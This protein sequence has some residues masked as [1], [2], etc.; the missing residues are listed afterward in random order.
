MWYDQ[1][2][3]TYILYVYVWICMYGYVWVN[4]YIYMYWCKCTNMYVLHV[5]ACKYVLNV[6]QVYAC[7]VCISMYACI[8]CIACICM[9][10]W[11]TLLEIHANTYIYMQYT[12]ILKYM[13][14]MHNVSMHVLSSIYVQIWSLFFR[15]MKTLTSCFTHAPPSPH[16]AILIRIT[17]CELTMSC[18]VFPGSVS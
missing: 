9:Y 7:L 13:Q 16:L 4:A 18:A 8:V 3:N 17:S 6:S 10:F 15:N 14:D 2:L 1:C 11:I 12:N 5:L